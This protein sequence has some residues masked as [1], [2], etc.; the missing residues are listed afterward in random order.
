MQF[1]EFGIRH[2]VALF[3]AVDKSRC[4]SQAPLALDKLHASALLSPHG[5]GESS[6]M[7]RDGAK[8]HDSFRQ[9]FMADETHTLPVTLLGLEPHTLIVFCSGRLM[10]VSRKVISTLWKESWR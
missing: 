7:G 2:S 3:G 4:D 9:R 1:A 10:S 5:V 8:V 6:V